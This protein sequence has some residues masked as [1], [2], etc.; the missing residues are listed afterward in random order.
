MRRIVISKGK[1]AKVGP[2]HTRDITIGDILDCFFPEKG[3]EYSYLGYAYYTPKTVVGDILLDFFKKVDKAARPKWCPK[4][5]IR[6]LHLFGNDNSVVRMRNFYIQN[7]FCKITK[8]IMI[9]DMKW[10]YDTF[11]IYG[12]FTRELDDL[13]KEVCEKITKI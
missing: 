5:Y 11:R 1:P 7:K 10:K 6:L 12:R 2:V 3:E 4:F 9:S 13:S 8:G